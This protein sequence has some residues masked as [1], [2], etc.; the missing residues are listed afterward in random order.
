MTHAP[1]ISAPPPNTPAH[2]S[3]RGRTVPARLLRLLAAVCAL[4][5]VFLIVMLMITGGGVYWLTRTEGGQAF[6][7]QQLESASAAT[8]YTVTLDGVRVSGP[9]AIGLSNL[10]I[11]DQD[12]VFLT[13][14]NVR[15]GINVLALPARTLDL[16]LS[17]DTTDLARIPIAADDATQSENAAAESAPLEP[18]T[19]PALYISRI[20]LG[21]LAIDRLTLAPGVAGEEALVLSPVLDARVTL[22][23]DTVTFT[24]SLTDRMQAGVLP[25]TADIDG[26]FNTQSLLLT[27]TDATITHPDY[28]LSAQGTAG[29]GDNGPLDMALA[30]KATLTGALAVPDMDGALA[31]EARISGQTHAPAFDISAQMTSDALA[32]RGLTDI[33]LTAALPPYDDAIDTARHGRADLS[34]TYQ[35]RPVTLGADITHDDTGFTL[36]A[37]TIA[38]PALTGEG[39]ARFPA[40]DY[41]PNAQLTVT[42]S[43]LAAWQDLIGVALKGRIKADITLVTQTTPADT[44]ADLASAT[45]LSVRANAADFAYDTVDAPAA[46]IDVRV[47]D[48]TRPLLNADA[49][50]SAPEITVSGNR[51]TRVE[52]AVKPSNAESLSADIALRLPAYGA[53]IKAT[54]DVIGTDIETATIRNL[55]ATAAFGA[56]GTVTVTGGADMAALALDISAK[57]LLPLRIAAQANPALA[58]MAFSDAPV[59][60]TITLRGTAAA[61]VI[62]GDMTA[63]SAVDVGDTPMRLTVTAAPSYAGEKLSLSASAKGDGIR[64]ATVAVTQPMHLSLYPFDVAFDTA[65]PMTGDVNLALDLAPLSALALEPAISATGG[66]TAKATLSGSLSAPRINGTATLDNA[67]LVMHQSGVAL[68]DIAASADFAGDRVTITRLSARDDG[69]GTI[70]GTADIGLAGGFPLDAGV[71]M[72]TINLFGRSRTVSGLLSG[73]FALKGRD[74]DYTASGT[75]TSDEI[76]ITIPERFSENIPTL[77]VVEKRAAEKSPLLETLALDVAFIAENRIFVRGWGLDAEFG[78]SL[79][80][81]GTLAE[82]LVSGTLSSRRGRYEEFGRRFTLSRANLAFRGAVPPSPYLDIVATTDT[83]DIVANVNITGSAEKPELDFTSVPALPRDEVLSRILFGREMGRISPFQA[84]ELART[85]RRLSGQGGGA[86]PLGTLRGATGLD[87]LSV[88]TSD[89]GATSVGAGKYLSDKVYLELESGSGEKSGAAKV[90]VEMTPNINLESRVGQDATGGGGVFWKWDY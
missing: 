73:D 74:G 32:A 60:G 84:L 81:G 58:D 28:A 17:A 11:A 18:F 78:G 19:L 4:I 16:S 50:L 43:D 89:D 1:H 47:P 9:G 49:R 86:D 85:M 83:G 25:R 40:P 6:L 15:L 80:I 64:T 14:H 5:L 88:S 53:D 56:N 20:K 67:A 34:A 36:P 3:A 70:T 71:Q 21:T 35:N 79:D 33:A 24:A 30:A 46:R 29:L 77:N 61:P 31:A 90:K 76:N 54:A 22:E 44:T 69:A 41:H 82:P 23:S 10:A 27:L 42:A 37:I 52:A 51:I 13:A 63:T 38:A 66:M 65:A 62:A 2:P 87:D 55:N 45:S 57:S 68:R 59:N 72:N 26:N 48:I 8:G 39:S 12:G 75:I 7:E